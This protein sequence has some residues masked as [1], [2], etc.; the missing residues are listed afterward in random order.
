[1]YPFEPKASFQVVRNYHEEITAYGFPSTVETMIQNIW[2]VSKLTQVYKDAPQLCKNWKF[3]HATPCKLPG[4][5]LMSERFDTR[6]PFEVTGTNFTGPFLTSWETNAEFCTSAFCW[7]LHL[8]CFSVWVRTECTDHICK[9]LKDSSL[10]NVS[11]L[12][13][14]GRTIIR[15]SILQQRRNYSVLNAM[16]HN[17]TQFL[18]FQL[19]RSNV[20]ENDQLDQLLEKTNQL[21]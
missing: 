6:Y 9:H 1:M 10:H 20:R 21:S 7:C 17:G 18:P 19:T 5:N 8:C 12:Q 13:L 16:K 11:G 2:L 3:V 14:L 4:G 15:R